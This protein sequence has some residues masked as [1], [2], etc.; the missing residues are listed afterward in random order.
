MIKLILADMDGT[1]LPF[2]SRVG[3]ERTHS[4]ILSALDAGIACGPASGRDYAD[5]AV[6]GGFY[7][8]GSW[9]A[10][11][12]SRYIKRY[13]NSGRF[14]KQFSNLKTGEKGE[15]DYFKQSNFRIQRTHSQ[16]P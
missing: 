10:S 5:L 3:S 7:T 1:L 12:A 16:D 13:K 15:P 8:L 14:N 6:R 2:G 11:A 4:A 9:E